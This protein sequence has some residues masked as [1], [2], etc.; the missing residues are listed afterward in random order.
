MSG[1]MSGIARGLV[2]YPNRWPHQVTARLNF[3]NKYLSA[4]GQATP[5]ISDYMEQIAICT[6]QWKSGLLHSPARN[7]PTCHSRISEKDKILSRILIQVGINKRNGR[8]ARKQ[9][10]RKAVRPMPSLPR[11]PHS[12]CEDKRVH[13]DSP[14]I[15]R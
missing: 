2:S 3:E 6:T 10:A 9:I 14:P 13:T 12:R 11:Y 1:Y 4:Y 7:L 5:A 15:V 8:L